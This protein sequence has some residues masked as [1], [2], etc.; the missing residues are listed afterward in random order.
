MRSV[1]GTKAE[2]TSSATTLRYYLSADETI[3]PEED[4]EVGSDRVDALSGRGASANRR[5]SDISETLIAPDTPGVHYYGVCIDAAEDESNTSNNCSQT[6]EITVEA[7]PPDPTIPADPVL[8]PRPEAPDLVIS[9]QRVDKSTIKQGQG[10]RLHITLTN[11][12][13]RPAPATKIRFYRSTDATIS[14]EEDT[15]LR[16]VPVGGLGPGKS[17]TT[18]GLLPSPFA[19]GVYYYG[20]CLDAVTSEFDTTNNCSDAIEIIVVLQ[21]DPIDGLESRGRIPAQTLKVEESPEPLSASRYFAGKVDT[22]ETRSSKPAV[23]TVS[24]EANSDLLKLTPVSRGHSV[25]TVTAHH[26]NTTAQQTFDVYVGI[27]PTRVLR[28]GTPVPPQPLAVGG[29]PLVLDVSGNVTGQVETWRAVSSHL[30]VVVVSLSGSVV[31]LTPG[32]EGNA[33]VTIHAS[34]GIS[35]VQHTFRVF[36]GAAGEPDLKWVIP[37]PPQTLVVG[38]SPVVLDVSGYVAGEV[39]TWAAVSSNETAVTASLSGSVVTLTPGSEGSSEVTI[40]ARR[41]DLE[42]SGTF[43]VSVGAADGLEW[44]VPI[45]P[46]TLVVGRSPVVLDVSGH[47]VGEVETWQAS[48]SNE[49]VV[50]AS[51][52]GSVVTLTPV[53]AGSAEVT[54][55]ARRGDLE[56]SGTFSVSVAPDTSPVVSIPDASLRAAI[57]SALGLSGGDTIT[58]QAMQGLTVLSAGSSGISDLTGLEHATRLT[59]LD[60]FDN[61]VSNINALANL[62][63]LTGLGLT[64]NQVSNITPLANLTALT[65]LGLGDN[66]ISDITPLANLT[67]LTQLGLTRNQVSNI[68]PL[69]NLT[70]LTQLGLTQNQVSNITP[71]AN[72]TT[73]TKLTLSNNGISDITSLQ[74]LTALTQLVLWSNQIS[75]I[76]ALANLTALTELMLGYNQISDITPIQNLTALSYVLD[77]RGNQ[78]TD[79]TPLENLT[80]LSQL[81]LE[82]NPIADLAPLRTLKENNPSVQIDIDINAPLAPSAPV[83]PA[84]TALFPNYPN[85]FNPETWIPYQLAPSADVTLTIYDVRGVMVWRL[86]LGHRPAGFYRSRGRAA[87]WDGR[88][89]IGEKV[90]TGLYFYTLTAGDFNATGKMLIQK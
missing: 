68:T 43:T 71:L 87:H 8:L 48:S 85:P 58:Q 75:N 12:G 76:S 51:L 32:S 45:P 5:R 13:L 49:G 80:V 84:E 39:E 54:I 66:L 73:L 11:R 34:D 15:E 22:W 6:I 50:A 24:M 60:L 36:V 57:R 35:E 69:A 33:E 62:T 30:G 3:S 78:I 86:A 1:S 16:E 63:A 19:V 59:V 25:V 27:D 77:L 72:L 47:V 90:A 37:V 89:Q 83:F 2:R 74:N 7:P 81:Y 17:Y 38:R 67:A 20:A 40:S 42:V 10:V 26:G 21:S 70:A 82:G 4:T 44:G 29:S 65:G 18:W 28:W 23:V 53:S 64:Q 41:G 52:S 88:N 46:Q 61:Q 55:R 14:P 9:W 56:V 79:V 31:T